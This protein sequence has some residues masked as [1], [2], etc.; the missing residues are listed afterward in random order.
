[1]SL[2]Y[3]KKQ[4]QSS[5][6]DF[7]YD[8]LGEI[9]HFIKRIKKKHLTVPLLILKTIEWSIYRWYKTP[10][11]RFYGIKGNELIYMI[12]KRCNE[13]CPKCGIWKMP[14][15]E[16]DRVDIQYFINCLRQLRN[17][18]YQVTI[19]GGE[20]LLFIDE[21]IYIATETKILNIPLL[22]VSNGVLLTKEFLLEYQ[23]LGHILVISV[24]TLD[25]DKWK[26][27]RGTDSYDVVMNNIHM[28][29]SIL[30]DKLQIQSVL[31]N[32]TKEDISAIKS[33]C[34]KMQIRYVVQPYMDFGGIWHEVK[35]FDYNSNIM[36]AARKNICVYPNGD[37]VKCFDHHRIQRA[38]EPLGNIE[39]EDIISILCNKR[40]TEISKIMKSCNYKCKY[41][42]CNVPKLT[43]EE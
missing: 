3:R 18:L 4:D 21:I 11:R 37:V 43:Y 28:A 26:I 20:P 33:F 22:I 32:E 12:T 41:L 2:I 25:K 38:K 15:A 35:D 13:K 42:S 34:K 14:E 29:K 8:Y 16:N 10:I 7:I 24:D 39:K 31:A 19:T 27:F 9:Q 5:N 1:M 23:N 30:T 40:S 6:I 17:N 36:C